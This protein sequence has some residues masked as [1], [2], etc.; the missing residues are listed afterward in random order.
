MGDE[1][2][3]SIEKES[4]FDRSPLVVSPH[5]Q[6]II[7]GVFSLSRGKSILMSAEGV[8]SQ[9]SYVTLVCSISCIV[10][11]ALLQPGSQSHRYILN[12]ALLYR[13]PK[14]LLGDTFVSSIFFG[15]D[16]VSSFTTQAIQ[17]HTCNSLI[18]Y[19][20][21]SPFAA[22]FDSK[23]RQHIRYLHLSSKVLLSHFLV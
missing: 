10:P 12:C 20:Q 23:S 14:P 4:Q 7:K 1:L 6:L 22:H 11:L 5:V 3:V 17:G 19:L 21:V 16:S 9:S 2:P 15:F 18:L 8:L 13:I